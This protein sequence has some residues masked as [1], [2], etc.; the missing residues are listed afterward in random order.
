M[1]SGINPS[2]RQDNSKRGAKNKNKINSGVSV[3]LSRTINMGSSI[4]L[5]Y[6]QSLL[7]QKRLNSRSVI[8]PNFNEQ[9]LDKEPP[10]EYSKNLLYLLMLFMIFQ[11]FGVYFIYDFPQLFEEVL[12]NKF[13]ITPLQV[14]YLYAAYSIP[15]FVS[16]PLISVI[17]NYTGLGYG[18][19]ML[20]S[21][22]YFSSMIMYYA[23][24]HEIYWLMLVA[25]AV[26]GVGGESLLIA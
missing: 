17:L 6:Q 15:N 14:S 3:S 9:D 22:V 23:S 4:T 8:D 1:K 25:R 10:I 7:K 12:I 2:F 16:A 13:E 5:A 18:T 26:Y 19:V 11:N 21:L 24:Q 20:S